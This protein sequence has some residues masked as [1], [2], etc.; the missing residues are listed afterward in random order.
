MR[1]VF[2]GTPEFAG[3]ILK[4]LVHQG[5][6]VAAVVTVAD[7]P[8]GRG[9]KLHESAVKRIAL[10]FQLPVLQPVK[11]KDPEFLEQLSEYQ[12]DVFVVVAFRMLPEVVWNMPPKGTFNI[13]ASLLPHYR[14]AAPINWAVINGESET[15]VTTFFLNHDIDAGD[16]IAKRTVKINP[17]ETAGSLH[18]RLCEEGKIIALETLKMIDEISIK[19]ITQA[20]IDVGKLKIA[21]KLFKPDCKID[22]SKD[23]FLINQLIRGLSPYPASFFEMKNKSDE[24]LSMK[25]FSAEV[26]ISDSES[27]VGAISS[28]YKHFF[29]VRC[30]D[31]WISLKDVQL[32]GKKRMGVEEFL[33]G[34]RFNCEDLKLHS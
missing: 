24:L 13:H 33:R 1:I 11:L 10:E 3:E 32:M 30:N 23:G 25:V 5:V 9:Q 6:D 17:D 28:D 20:N 29:K 12:A 34:F 27:P 21:P 16:I 14:G 18:D 7:K 31:S 19:P 4:Q 2:M 8:A 26:E 22:F 15:G